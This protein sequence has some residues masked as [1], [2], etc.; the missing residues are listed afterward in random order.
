MNQR[1]LEETWM[2]LETALGDDTKRAQSHRISIRTVNTSRLTSF[3]LNSASFR[4]TKEPISVNQ[5][6]K[7]YK[8]KCD[9]IRIP[10]LP[11]QESRFIT[12]CVNNFKNRH[13]HM[14]E[15][16]LALQSAYVI[17]RVLKTSNFAYVDLSKNSLSCEG[18]FVLLKEISDS[19]T[20]VHLDLSNNE[21]TPEGFDNIAKI[22]SYHPSII[23]VD[24]SS[25]EG[26]HRNRLSNSG[27]MSL[28]Q[29]LTCNPLLQFIGLSGTGLSDGI[30]FIAQGIT[31]NYNLVSLDLSNNALNGKM[32][33]CLTKAVV[34]TELKILNLGFNKICDEGCEF[35]SNMILGAYEAACPLINLNIS[36][37]GIASKGA[38][39]IF[40]SLRL[41]ILIK[42][43]NISNN[44]FQ[45]GLTTFFTTF[46]SDNCVMKSLNLSNCG[47]KSDH[48]QNVSDGLIKNTKLENLI[49]S[50]NK[51]ED[52]GAQ[53]I[54]FGL[55]KNTGLKSIDLSSCA[56]KG[57]GVLSIAKSLRN[58]FTLNSINLKD[59]SVKDDSGEIF[60]E[61]TR[62]NKNFLSV[63]LDLNPVNLKFVESIKLNLKENRRLYKKM[64]IPKIRE[65]ID[66]MRIP[67]ETYENLNVKNRLR[68][69]KKAEIERRHEIHDESFEEVK[70]KEQKKTQAMVQEHKILREKNVELAL[71][72][73]ATQ[74]ETIKTRVQ[75]ER[76]VEEMNLKLRITDIEIEKNGKKLNSTK[77]VNE[78]K[79][80]TVNSAL[81]EYRDKYQEQE[82]GRRALERT[83][84]N[85]K[86]LLE[87]QKRQI[88]T[89]KTCKT[90]ANLRPSK[91][92]R[93]PAE[94]LA[95][96]KLAMNK[97]KYSPK[98]KQ[99]PLLK[100]QRSSSATK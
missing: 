74:S 18:V 94:F 33:E 53:H 97:K 66:R 100:T 5:L 46:F 34:K 55:T 45:Q 25:Y 72:I 36:H 13:F 54:A 1:Y 48:L 93:I 50:H 88:E 2:R 59:N 40:H 19:Q 76:K 7:I 69:E 22:L 58:N 80:N 31:E 27:A 52:T 49:L 60:V 78:A 79:K 35:I 86:S 26:L 70:E 65:E 91:S 12:F 92:N 83:L 71:A 98:K 20:I 99:K 82:M 17:G 28:C 47:I 15:A 63:N 16:G 62:L 90:M 6:K 4:S 51:I 37:N 3:R 87:E 64:Q 32:M 9:D 56:I 11:D 75:N 41:N 85:L 29:A 21:I 96:E 43:F 61:I 38:G 8:A 68:L 73:D 57:Q 77:E 84:T 39:K 24:F 89:L 67:I 23:S 95:S 10:V 44:Q 14:K 81:A 42:D 30:E